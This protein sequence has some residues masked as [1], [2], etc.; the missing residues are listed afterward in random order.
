MVEIPQLPWFDLPPATRT[1]GQPLRDNRGEPQTR[2]LVLPAIPLR[3]SRTSH[4]KPKR[5]VGETG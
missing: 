1:G 5:P 4:V 3:L 2:L